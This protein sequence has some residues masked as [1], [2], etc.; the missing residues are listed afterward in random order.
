MLISDSCFLH[1]LGSGE[2]ILVLQGVEDDSNKA[3]EGHGHDE[4]AV[5]VPQLGH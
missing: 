4:Q 3:K 2:L 5:I 1:G